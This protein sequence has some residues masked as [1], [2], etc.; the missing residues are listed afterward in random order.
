MKI[1]VSVLNKRQHWDNLA[2]AAEAQCST[3]SMFDLGVV[4]QTPTSVDE[5]VFTV[6][7]GSLA[8]KRQALSPWLPT[9]PIPQ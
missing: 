5:S 1:Q 8:K 4:A 6:V 2:K 3:L 9:A 7:M